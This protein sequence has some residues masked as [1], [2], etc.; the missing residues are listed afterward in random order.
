MQ[1]AFTHPRLPQV[2]DRLATHHEAVAHRAQAG[3]PP[4]D[5]PRLRC[6]ACGHESPRERDVAL[7]LRDSP[8]TVDGAEARWP[9]EAGEG[10]GAWLPS[11]VYLPAV[12]TPALPAAAFRVCYAR[13]L[14]ARAA[15]DLRA[16]ADVIETPPATLLDV[17]SADDGPGWAGAGRMVEYLGR[18]LAGRRGDMDVAGMGLPQVR[19]RPDHRARDTLVF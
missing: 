11:R 2:L 6:A 5:P 19:Y 12:W 15:S 9:W 14:P 3:L 1:P 17:A 10:V 13:T 7:A 16:V 8:T 4:P 18:C